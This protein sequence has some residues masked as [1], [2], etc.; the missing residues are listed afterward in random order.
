V[1][2]NYGRGRTVLFSTEGSWRWKM[3]LPHDD[4]TQPT[5]WQ[6]MLRHLVT[7]TP[8][9]VTSP[10]PSPCSPMRPRCRAGGGARQTIQPVTNAKVQARFMG[11]DGA[12]ATVELAPQPL[13]E[14]STPGNGPRK[15]P[16]YVADIIA[17]REQEEVGRD[18]VTFRREDGVAEN[19]RTS[20]NRK[21]LEKA[22]QSD[23]RP[24]L[25]AR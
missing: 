22:L 23:R 13:E 24:L 6:Q 3:W 10:R 8:G 15:S 9:Q 2:E 1:T 16:A 12:S 11:P 4:K 5:F 19:F 18:V 25:Q 20:Q 17:G 7:D 14:A 21:L